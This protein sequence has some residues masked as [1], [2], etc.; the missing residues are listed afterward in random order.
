MKYFAVLYALGVIFSLSSGLV[1]VPLHKSNRT[2]PLLSHEL[3]QQA[4][5]WKYREL[6]NP[7][8]GSP[9]PL[10]NY[11]DVEYYG[12]I[13]IGTPPQTF[14][15]VFDTGSSNLWVPSSKCDP[16]DKAC[17][18]HRKYDS[19]KS[20]TYVP[21]GRKFAIK[22]G[23]GSLSGFL[24]AD[25]VCVGSLCVKNQTFG[26]ATEQPGETFVDA[27]SD[28]ILG[29]AYSSIAEDGVTPVFYNMVSQ[30]LVNEPIFAFYLDR[31]E[32]AKTGGELDLGGVDSTHYTGEIYYEEVIQEEYWMIEMDSVSVGGT[33]ICTKCRAIAD[34]GT[35]LIVGPTAEIANIQKIIGAVEHSGGDYT[36]DCSQ[37]DKLPNINI[38][39]GGHNFVLTPKEYILVESEDGVTYCIS[40]FMGMQLDFFILGDVFLGAYYS[41][42]D[43][44]NNRVGFAESQ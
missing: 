6:I 8:S 10:V 33:T 41:V 20:S 19:S 21:N 36:V 25:T 26:E 14:T 29:M 28:G 23:E 44:G 34:T 22:Y 7:T 13:T 5:E 30:H 11:L 15:V 2:A 39:L 3:R 16:A 43:L 37:M 9:E 32:G 38:V 24:S 31:K 12:D 42:F 18:T 40:G 17:A 35:S 1:R 4:L 27:K